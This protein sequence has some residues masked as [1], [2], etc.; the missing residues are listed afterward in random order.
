LLLAFFLPIGEPLVCPA[1]QQ[2]LRHPEE[3][4]F[5]GLLR[6]RGGS[7]PSEYEQ[8]PGNDSRLARPGAQ[9]MAYQADASPIYTAPIGPG[10]AALVHA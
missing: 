8:Q 5:L 3:L 4:P 2:P 9:P 1:C 7:N 6:H 10:F